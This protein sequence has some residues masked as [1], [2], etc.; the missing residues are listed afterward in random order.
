MRMP[1][2]LIVCCGV[3]LIAQSARAIDGSPVLVVG[4]LLGQLG[5]TSDPYVDVDQA[6][7]SNDFD[8]AIRLL[9][10]VR[11]NARFNDNQ[12][13][14]QESL[15]RTKEVRQLKARFTKVA[16]AMETLE[17]SPDDQTAN[18]IIGLFECTEK[19]N[20]LNGLQL[21]AK[22]DDPDLRELAEKDLANPTDAEAQLA[23]A[24]AWWAYADGQPAAARRPF[25]LRGR[26]WYIVARPN[27]AA[28]DRAGP[29][30]RLDRMPLF[31]DRIVLWNQHN[32]PAQNRGT[33]ECVVTLY[34]DGKEKYRKLVAMPWSG[35]SPAWCLLRT[36]R[37]QVDSIR[38]DITR[39]R[40]VGGGLAEIEIYD[41]HTNIAARCSAVAI[42]YWEDNT[43]FHPRKLTDGDVSG[44]ADGMWLLQDNVQ[45]WAIVDLVKLRDQP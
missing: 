13:L 12:A 5:F 16:G 17:R 2:R 25:E 36:P 3:S 7:A 9:D 42:H 32:G 37:V 14:Q 22:G 40:G 8:E 33:V 41:G 19:G 20:W 24:E 44:H 28:S 45:G 23:L 6:I 43:Y 30:R 38:V 11:S 4:H 26:G 29:D 21:L 31:A 10:D 39:H 15:E 34:K 18:R 27:L 35:E 1:I